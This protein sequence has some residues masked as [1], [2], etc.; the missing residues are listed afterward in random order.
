MIIS[1]KYKFIY[2]KNVKVG[3]S[4]LEIYLTKFHLNN[5]LQ[6][7]MEARYKEIRGVKAELNEI[8]SK[9]IYVT[10]Y[11][12][13]HNGSKFIKNKFPKKINNYYKFCI[14]RNPYDRFVSR[15]FWDLK[16]NE[17]PK[18]ITFEQYII[19]ESKKKI[20][21]MNDDW[22]DRCTLDGKPICNFY[23]RFDN[24]DEDVKVVLKKLGIE[25]KKI[26]RINE[27]K[28][29]PE[30][31]YREYYNNNTKKILYDN[32]KKEIEFFKYKF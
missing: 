22:Y 26:E 31:N 4:S 29:K 8:I 6:K 18:N 12:S 3:G 19:N 11:P 32:C 5:E 30:R 10:S 27:N 1:D 20:N 23:I 28:L 25:N 15:Y 14:V 21:K 24:Y 13:A 9:D 17:I 16:I 7:K 2:L